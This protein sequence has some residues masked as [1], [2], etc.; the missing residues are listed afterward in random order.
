MFNTIVEK[1]ELFQQEQR[2]AALAVF[3]IHKV[4]IF[5]IGN[6]ADGTKIGEYKDGAYKTLRRKEGREVSFVNLDFRGSMRKDYQPTK[7][8]IVGYGFSNKN[9]LDK[10]NWNEE[11]FKKAVFF[12][13][14]SERQLYVDTVSDLIFGKR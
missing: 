11:H 6:A 10:A 4:R 3:A 9:E 13:S 2:K 1:L 8:G 12:L 14:A 7:T 5:Q